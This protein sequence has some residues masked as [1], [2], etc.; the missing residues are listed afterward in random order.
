MI[1][2]RFEMDTDLTVEDYLLFAGRAKIPADLHKI[3]ALKNLHL[4]RDGKMTNAGAWLLAEDIRKFNI[5][6]TVSCALFMGNTKLHI[7]DR[8]DFSRDIYTNFQDV[9]SYLLS[10]LNT[11]FIITGTGRDE[12]LELPVDALREALVNA[13]AH[14]DY[15]ST[16]NIQVHIFHDRVEIISPG[17]L[18]AGMKEE[19]LGLKSIPRNPLLFGILYRM[20]I[21][22]QVGSGIR[23]IRQ[24]CHDYGVGTP[25]VQVEENWV[26]VVF[27]RNTGSPEGV[28]TQVT[29]QVVPL[30]P[31][32]NR[33][34]VVSCR[35]NSGY[36]I[37]SIFGSNI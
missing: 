5:S 12:R 36:V 4:I 17:G 1:N 7:L 13:L 35:I 8:K 2:D 24:L 3:Q 18:P 29:T 37:V 10:K 19:D 15:R 26:T 34:V 30:L 21:V 31:W 33:S 32:I 16:A 11:A 25:Q 9:I 23:R 20:D 6:A 22:E 28:T 27:E 14:R